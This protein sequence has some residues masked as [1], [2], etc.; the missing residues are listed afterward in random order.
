M[1]QFPLLIDSLGICRA[2]LR[3]GFGLLGNMHMSKE[4][5]ISESRSSSILAEAWIYTRNSLGASDAH[6]R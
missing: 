3:P 2:V 6:L 5:I 1:F 4:F